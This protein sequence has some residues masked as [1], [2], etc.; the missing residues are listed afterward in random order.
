[1]SRRVALVRFAPLEGGKEL[2][3]LNVGLE[4]GKELSHVQLGGGGVER[5]EWVE[6]DGLLCC[7]ADGTAVIFAPPPS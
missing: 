6:A 1:M 5:M 3:L 2:S 4:G 7:L